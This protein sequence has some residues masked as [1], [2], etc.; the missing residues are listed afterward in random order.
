MLHLANV[1]FKDQNDNHHTPHSFQIQDHVW[2]HI[3]KE[4]FTSPYRML[5]P[6]RYGLDSI[7][8]QIGENY[9]QLNISACLGLHLVFNVDLLRPYHAPLLEH[10]DL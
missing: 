1:K 2:L 8:R 10:N 9:F 7:L 4:C 6:L 3:N 5:K